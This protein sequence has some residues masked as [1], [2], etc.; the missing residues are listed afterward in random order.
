MS[1][2]AMVFVSSM[3]CKLLIVGVLV[4]MDS[5]SSLNVTQ[6]LPNMSS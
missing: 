4:I 5:Y 6:S 2:S 1:V 3:K